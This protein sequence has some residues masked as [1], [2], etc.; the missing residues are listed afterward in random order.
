MTEPWFDANS[1]AWIPG[2][3]MG[4]LAGLWGSVAG[5]LAPQ[6]KGKGLV[7][8]MAA[9]LLG[10]AAVLVGLGLYA[11]LTGQP[12][13]IWYGLGFP[14]LLILVI[15]IPLLIVVGNRYREAEQRRMAAQDIP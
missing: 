5:M 13:G 8:G 4:C 14:G 7:F 12:Y 10:C 6:G 1:Y 2:T 11:L 3:A 15:L 9:L